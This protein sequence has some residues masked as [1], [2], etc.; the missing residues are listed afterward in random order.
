MKRSVVKVVA[1]LVCALMLTGCTINV[2]A[3]VPNNTTHEENAELKHDDVISGN[4]TDVETP[5][6]NPEPSPET[7][8]PA[9][10]IPKT[11]SVERD[12]QNNFEEAKQSAIYRGY[13]ADGNIIWEYQTEEVYVGQYVG[14]SLPIINNDGV[15]FVCGGKLYCIDINTE[16]YGKVKWISPEDVG[17]GCSM[18]FDENGNIYVLAYEMPGYY[19]ID[20]N[21]KT[22]AHIEKFGF[23]DPTD[24]DYYFWNES[25]VYVNGYVIIYFDSLCE[26]K[27]FEAATG[28]EKIQDFDLS[29]IEGTEW[30]FT[31]IEVED[32]RQSAENY[33]FSYK[34]SFDE[35]CYMSF[36]E[37]DSNNKCTNKFENMES[38]AFLD[39]SSLYENKTEWYLEC[40]YDDENCFDI[41]LLDDNSIYIYWYIG[42]WD[43][44]VY[45]TVVTIYFD[46]IK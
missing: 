20:K 27:Y 32:Y 13:D 46:K 14:L 22:V 1:T 2:N 45:P 24:E 31:E 30:A 12:I 11:F 34:L 10:N 29:A 41:Y 23:E 17:S 7:D 40:E 28:I 6:N 5:T 15:Y 8:T 36:Y 18:D 43:E 9:V 3:P 38:E 25:I 44:D 39:L 35:N 16:N 19:I 33:E 26:N 21:G 4:N 42:A 37:Y